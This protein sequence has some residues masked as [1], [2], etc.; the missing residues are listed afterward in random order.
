MTRSV[1]SGISAKSLTIIASRRPRRAVRGRHGG[2]HPGVE[3]AAEL[4]DQALLVLGQLWVA[5]RED[6]LS[7]ARH[8]TQELHR[9]GL[10]QRGSRPARGPQP[11]PPRPGRP[12][13]RPRRR[14]RAGRRA[15]PPTPRA[16]AATRRLERRQTEREVRGERRRVRAARAVRGAVRIAR[17]RDRHVALAVAE[18]VDRVRVAGVPAGDHDVARA[19]RQRS[20]GPARAASPPASPARLVEQRA[21]LEQVRRHDGRAR[22]QLDA[23]PA[24]PRVRAAGRRS[25]TPSPDRAPPARPA[26][27]RAPR[28]T[29]AIVSDESRACRSSPRRRRCRTPRPAPDRRSPPAGTGV[30]PS[31]AT[32]FCQV[33]AVIAVMPW[34]PQRANAFRSAWIPA[35]PPES[36]PA[37]DKH[38][39]D[40]SR[41]ASIAVKDRHRSS[42]ADVGAAGAAPH[43][44]QQLE[45]GEPGQH[46]A[47]LASRARHD[48]VRRRCPASTA[49]SSASSRGSSGASRERRRGPLAAPDAVQ[50]VEHVGRRAHDASAV[51]QQRVRARRRARD[52]TCPGTAPTS[53][54]RSCANCAVISEPDV[55]GALD[56]DRHV[57]EPGHD[58]VARRK[59][60]LQRRRAGRQL[61]DHEALLAQPPVKRR[62]ANADTR[63]PHPTASRRPPD[64]CPPARPRVR[65]RRRRTRDR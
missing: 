35:P 5:L 17:A 14:C 54:P 4:V 40:P 63:R 27:G 16:F 15:P 21:R 61:G 18:V 3:L 34:T 11:A 53:R 23:A 20:R 10:C 30:T 42:A 31:T 56:H 64:R 46:V 44:A 8:Q 9:A 28:R 37:I 55:G 45:L 32:V 26:P 58:P 51:G 33:I 2:P 39:R 7:P 59:A 52:V 62:D 38:P 43:Q 13:A 6:D 24:A 25:R 60:P 48:R 49:S 50:R 36:E 1:P 41:C 22:Q 57:R 19:E 12:R 29:A 65:P 47:D